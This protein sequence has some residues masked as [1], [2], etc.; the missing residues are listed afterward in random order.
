VSNDTPAPPF[1]G[2]FRAHR[3]PPKP[4]SPPVTARH[5]LG[6][7]KLSPTTDSRPPSSAECRP[8]LHRCRRSS[9]PRRRQ[10]PVP[11]RRKSSTPVSNLPLIVLVP[12]I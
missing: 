1:L 10:A 12:Q 3:R 5:R 8:L 7:R 2:V 6:K 9:E 4:L 11:P